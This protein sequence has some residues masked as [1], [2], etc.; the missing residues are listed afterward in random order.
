MLA[1]PPPSA[2][3]SELSLHENLQSVCR[4]QNVAHSI[5]LAHTAAAYSI[6]ALLRAAALFCFVRS[7]LGLEEKLVGSNTNACR[8]AKS[9]E[10]YEA[11]KPLWACCM[12]SVSWI[13]YPTLFA[14]FR[15]FRRQQ[16]QQ[17]ESTEPTAVRRPLPSSKPLITALYQCECE[18]EQSWQR[19]GQRA[20]FATI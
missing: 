5:R 4:C 8:L 12:C 18:G 14:F 9:L 7:S 2:F 10:R 20:F 15:L 16:Q 6:A 19:H 17:H 11:T 1:C 13:D 3:R